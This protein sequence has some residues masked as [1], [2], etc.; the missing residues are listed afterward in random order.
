MQ[1][2]GQQM[3]FSFLLLFNLDYSKGLS[4]FSPAGSTAGWGHRV[5]SFVTPPPAG[6]RWGPRKEEHTPRTEGIFL[7][8]SVWGEG[9]LQG[10]VGGGCGGQASGVRS[11][12]KWLMAS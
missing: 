6:E 1:P 3:H 8:E 10:V 12:I 11:S 7:I 2:K 5:P 9:L 4:A